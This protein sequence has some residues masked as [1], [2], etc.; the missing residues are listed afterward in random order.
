MQVMV[1]IGSDSDYEVIKDALDIL[2]DFGVTHSFEV[3]FIEHPYIPN[4]DLVMIKIR[5]I[6]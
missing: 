4:R 1:L 3:H 2:R 5:G 6:I